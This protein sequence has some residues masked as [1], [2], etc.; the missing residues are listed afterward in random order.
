MHTW[1]GWMLISWI[2]K[3][4]GKEEFQSLAAWEKLRSAESKYIEIQF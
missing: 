3:H 1:N 2:R 4:S